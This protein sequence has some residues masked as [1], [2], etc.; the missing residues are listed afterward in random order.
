MVIV[1]SLAMQTI[2]SKEERCNGVN[3]M[4][5]GIRCSS[6]VV[7]VTPTKSTDNY[8]NIGPHCAS[9]IFPSTSSSCV[10]DRSSVFVNHR[11]RKWR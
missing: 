5:A 9:S 1:I 10:Y 8:F 11:H 2:M 4:R 3:P 6:A 7:L